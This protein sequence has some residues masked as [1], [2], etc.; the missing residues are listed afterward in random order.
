MK[1][2]LLVIFVITQLANAQEYS[3]SEKSVIGVF[4]VPNKSKAEVFSTITKWVSINYNSSKNVTQL[5]DLEAGNIIIK[6]I[7]AVTYKNNAK[8]LYPNNKYI[9]D[10]TTSN[11]N[12]LIEINVKD[13]K[14]R[15][16]YTITDIA[17][18][19]NIYKDIMYNCI[20]F[21]SVKDEKV[22]EYNVMLESLLKGSYMGKG[23]RET[24]KSISK[25]IFI[26]LSEAVVMDIKKTMISIENSVASIK[27]DGW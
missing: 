19:E 17:D 22:D 2:L 21:V 27:N 5:S 24:L 4:E 25:Q 15:I 16:I 14:F 1:K 18:K 26:D 13:N 9:A 3:Y 20:D 11:F 10:Q 7:N 8:A 12:H 6:G 23:K